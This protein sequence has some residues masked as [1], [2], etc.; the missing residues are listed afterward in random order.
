MAEG[1][2]LTYSISYLM[3]ST[4]DWAGAL[5]KARL[6]REIADVLKEGQPAQEKEK[7]KEKEEKT[8]QKA[9][10]TTEELRQFREKCAAEIMSA[11]NKLIRRADHELGKKE[12]LEVGSGVRIG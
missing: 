10:E 4:G 5:L 7:E 9:K 3:Q 2:F 12:K 11:T 8:L 1:E 6:V